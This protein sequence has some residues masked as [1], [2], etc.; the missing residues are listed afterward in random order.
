[1]SIPKPVFK[2]PFNMTRA[3]HV[4]LRVRDLARS[5]A[6]Y[7][8][9]LGFVVTERQPERLYLRGLEEACHH[10]LVLEAASG[11]GCTRIGMRVL[12]HEDLDGAKA[13]FESKGLPAHWAEVE[14]QRRTLHATDPV[15]VPLEICANMDTRPRQILAATAFRGACPQRLDHF[16][17][18]TPQVREALDFY[19]G[20]GFRLSEYI[21]MDGSDEPTAVFLQRKG[22]P[23][24]I[25]FARGSGP[26]L[27]HAAFV[28]PETYHLMFVC[29]QLAENGF[30][31]SVEFGPCRHFAPGFA[32]FV[33]LRDPDGH[34]IEFFTTHYQTIDSE[35]EPVRWDASQLGM[36]WGA[37]PPESWLSEASSFTD[38][39]L[40]PEPVDATFG[41]L[42]KPS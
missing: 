40:R 13:W 22:N 19:T 35:D 25:V 23:H 30:G 11:P 10:S 16:Q 5:Y 3:S 26:R 21:A 20:M 8:D 38:V 39:A 32:R 36:G 29:D 4:V 37:R 27:H 17:I 12:T 34:R 41:K 42:L 6:F 18:V 31:K 28:V 14:H 2:P 15:G 33:Y 9:T 24:D 7:V 1:M